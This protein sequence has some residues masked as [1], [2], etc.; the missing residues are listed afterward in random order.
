MDLEIFKKEYV[1]KNTLYLQFSQNET[2]KKAVQHVRYVC[3]DYIYGKC[4]VNQFENGF[5][6]VQKLRKCPCVKFS[7]SFLDN[8]MPHRKMTIAPLNSP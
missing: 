8:S 5:H 3:I 4:Q 6:I 7:N 2:L 1:E